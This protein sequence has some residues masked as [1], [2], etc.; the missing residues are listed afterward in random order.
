MGSERAMAPTYA[1]GIP[2][3]SLLALGIGG[4]PNESSGYGYCVTRA[5][6]QAPAAC[7]ESSTRLPVFAGQKHDQSCHHGCRLVAAVLP[8]R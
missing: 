7:P 5:A 4:G 3:P 6:C 1:V 8:P 2:I